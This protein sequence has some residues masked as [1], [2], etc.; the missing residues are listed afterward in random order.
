M[1]KVSSFRFLDNHTTPSFI[2]GTH[3]SLNDSQFQE[4]VRWDPDSLCIP[5]GLIASDW[6]KN[7]QIYHLTMLLTR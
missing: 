1:L 2:L 7:K 3:V 5:D 4:N 6:G